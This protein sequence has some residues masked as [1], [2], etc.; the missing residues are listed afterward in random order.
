ML[1][2]VVL[3]LAAVTLGPQYANAASKTAAPKPSD[4][5]LSQVVTDLNMAL[6]RP[7]ASCDPLYPA[8]VKINSSYLLFKREITRWENDFA[9]LA[10]AG[11]NAD[12]SGLGQFRLAIADLALKRRCLDIADQEYRQVL[13]V[14]AG[15]RYVALRD[16]AKVG[17]EDVRDARRG[18]PR[19]TKNPKLDQIEEEAYRGFGQVRRP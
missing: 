3:F 18:D 10:I 12:A 1:F 9:M 2:R 11:G 15:V 5:L 16:R 19:V 7:D 6:L 8:A 14:Y 4:E 17:I 13:T